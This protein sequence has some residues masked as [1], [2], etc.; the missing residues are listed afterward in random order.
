[1][2]RTSRTRLLYVLAAVLGPAALVGCFGGSQNP[3]YF[4]YL[5][6][7][8]DVVRTHAKP[9]GQ[10]YFADFD[11]LAFGL[12]VTPREAFQPAGGEQVLIA[13]VV[14]ANGQPRR[15]RR[16]EWLLEGVGHILE[17]DESGYFAGRGYKV[18]NRYA[19]SYTDLVEHRITRGNTDPA[20]DFT[21]PPGSTWC[22][23]SAAE[24]GA[25]SVTVWAPGVHDRDRHK[26]IVRTL[27]TNAVCQFPTPEAVRV[28]S[29]HVLSTRVVRRTD[30]EPLPGYRVRYTITDGLPATL[31]PGAKAESVK[32]PSA[33][34]F[35]LVSDKAG[36]ATVRL[37]QAKPAPGNSTL[38][39]EVIRESD[40]VVVGKTER[41]L[42]WQDV[43][44][45]LAVTAPPRAAV[46]DTVPVTISLGNHG[47]VESRRVSLR[48]TLPAGMEFDSSLPKARQDGADVQWELP[49]LPGGQ[50]QTVQTRVRL[51]KPGLQTLTLRGRTPDGHE[52]VYGAEVEG[53]EARLRVSRSGPEVAVLGEEVPV[54][55]EVANVGTGVVENVRVAVAYDP[56]LSHRTGRNP[57][58][59]VVPRLEA[60]K[61]E[62]LRILLKAN[63]IGRFNVRVT[64]SAEK[65]PSADTDVLTIDVRNAKLKLITEATPRAYI[66]QEVAWRLTVRN[67]GDIPLRNAILR[68]DFPPEVVYLRSNVDARAGKSAA[69]WNLGNLRPG[70]ERVVLATA[71]AV[72]VAG[73]AN[74]RATA[75]ADPELAPG[76]KARTV[77]LPGS[78][79]ITRSAERTVEVLGVPAVQVE[80]KDSDDPTSV[81]RRTA[82]TI[83]VV[84]SG[85]LAVEGVEVIATVPPQMQA[86]RGAGPTEGKADGPTV[87]F[88]PIDTLPPGKQATFTI[89]AAATAAGTGKLQVEVRGR[90]LGTPVRVEEATRILPGG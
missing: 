74:L 46:G 65:G 70:E 29:E 63:D 52:V 50:Q 82:Y 25:T 27:W 16:V 43:Q 77:E 7:A 34:V 39:I 89:D 40:N 75:S 18:D 79:L 41:Q 37:T 62:K 15:K 73:A 9:P 47:K 51:T 45:K 88:A 48:M 6:P 31:A 90:T 26:V 10:G 8:G 32:T 61:I 53:L 80:V 3:S 24:A 86:L 58:D 85:T 28:G 33:G 59:T 42:E 21:I 56:G 60:G 11:P 72:A 13:T 55:I 1:M 71:R 78:G 2:S 35:E 38:V 23:I 12:E 87:R 66:G 64:A 76:A 57:I 54:A 19:V 44:L 17:V 36:S 49:G 20:D 30:G 4:P 83:R 68:G 84:N 22:V 5:L 14:D 69:Q 67:D 81:G